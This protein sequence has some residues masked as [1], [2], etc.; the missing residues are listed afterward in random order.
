MTAF[1]DNLVLFVRHLRGLGF[2]L[3]PQS[4]GELSRAAVAVGLERREDVYHAFRSIIVIRPSEVPLFDEAFDLF[5]GRGAAVTPT[6]VIST[7][8]ADS[9]TTGLSGGFLGSRGS[10]VRG[11]CRSNRGLLQPSGWGGATSA[12]CRPQRA[13]RSAVSSPGW[14]GDRPM[15]G[16][17]ASP[18]RGTVPNRTYVGRCAEP[19]ARKASCSGS[20]CRSAAAGDGP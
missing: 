1:A 17:D 13:K 16:A 20:P 14:C 12:R 9:V 18:R 7:T 4:A 11:G 15:P 3:P 5:F 2:R 19:W 8:Q 10:R 6:P